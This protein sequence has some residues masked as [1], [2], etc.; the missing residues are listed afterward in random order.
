MDNLGMKQL[1]GM[2]FRRELREMERE[3]V[4]GLGFFSNK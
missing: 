3:R 2:G 1:R 4:L